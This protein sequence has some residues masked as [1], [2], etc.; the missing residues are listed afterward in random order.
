MKTKSKQPKMKN[1]QTKCSTCWS[2]RMCDEIKNKREKKTK[3]ERERERTW[4]TRAMRETERIHAYTQL[5]N[6]VVELIRLTNMS[7]RSQRK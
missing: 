5:N 1:K 4:I 2:R 3:P 7:I 6:K